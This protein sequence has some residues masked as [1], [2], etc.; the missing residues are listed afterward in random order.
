MQPQDLTLKLEQT[1]KYIHI[2]I[3]SHRRKTKPTPVGIPD[4]VMQ[5]M[6]KVKSQ[7]PCLGQWERLGSNTTMTE[8]EITE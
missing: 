1:Q 8:G 5:G 6:H 4:W 3:F 7:G 2:S